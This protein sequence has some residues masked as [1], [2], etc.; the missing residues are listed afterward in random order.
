E[1][2]RP[3]RASQGA[4]YLAVALAAQREMARLQGLYDEIAQEPA[5][6]KI[7]LIRRPDGPENIPPS[8]QPALPAPR[9]ADEDGDSDYADYDADRG[10]DE[11]SA[12]GNEV[13]R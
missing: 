13:S 4:K 10:E 7:T 6:I 1:Y 8:Q 12:D 3:K 5:E 9:D 2:E 11:E